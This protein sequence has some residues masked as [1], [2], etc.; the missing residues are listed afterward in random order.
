MKSFYLEGYSRTKAKASVNY[1]YLTI[2]N[3][4]SIERVTLRERHCVNIECESNRDR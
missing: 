2:L 4:I 1:L 3:N